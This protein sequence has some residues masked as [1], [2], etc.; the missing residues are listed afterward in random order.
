[1]SDQHWEYFTFDGIK[2]CDYGVW[3]SGEGTF[4]APERDV[5]IVQVPG[6]DGTL[7]IDNGR[8]KNIQIKYPCFMSGDFLKRFDEFKNAIL[9]KRGYLKLTDTYHIWGH[10]MA[11]I[12]GGISPK[13]GPY[14]KSAAFT[15]TFDAWPQFYLKTGETAEVFT[16]S[17]DE[18][19]VPAGVFPFRPLVEIVI[20]P[21]DT[22]G[23]GSV[24]IGGTTISYSGLPWDATHH[25]FIDCE[26]R[27]IYRN[28]VSVA[29]YFTLDDDEFFEVSPPSAYVSWTGSVFSVGITPRWWSL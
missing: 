29:E 27:Q 3:I 16:T 12:T 23:T 11:R 17:G 19:D 7:T 28:N 24:T 6:R 21:S 5:E 15:L 20:G 8:Y 4:V 26:T 14:N 10:R 18:M 9:Q 13:P 1:M 25:V 2:S 22:P